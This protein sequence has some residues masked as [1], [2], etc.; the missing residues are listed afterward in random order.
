MATK[1]YIHV[2]AASTLQHPNTEPVEVVVN[3]LGRIHPGTEDEEEMHVFIMTEKAA[4]EFFEYGLRQLD[5]PRCYFDVEVDEQGEPV[6]PV[7]YGPDK[8]LFA[9]GPDKP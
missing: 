6:G 1:R 5:D 8:L 4:R 9:H 3:L 2:I 7:S